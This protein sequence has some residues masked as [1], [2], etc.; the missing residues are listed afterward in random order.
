L[1]LANGAF[2]TH[3]LTV[4][5]DHTLQFPVGGVTI[6]PIPQGTARNAGL[7]SVELPPGIRKGDRYDIVVRQVTEAH[8]TTRPSPPPIGIPEADTPLVVVERPPR[9]FS[10]RQQAG[11]FQI[12]IVIS[13]KEQL[14]LSEERLLS[15][16]LW[17]QQS[18]PLHSR[19]HL[20]FKRYIDLVRGR[21]RGFG[22]DP[23]RIQPSPT[24][25]VPGWPE[26]GKDG[27]DDFGLLGGPHHTGKVTG[28]IYD[29]F[30]DFAGF[31]LLARDGH[32]HRF[33]SQEEEI[34]DL[35]HRAWLERILITVYPDR[36][37]PHSPKSIVLRRRPP[38]RAW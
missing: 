9:T 35:V 20:V 5:G 1:R 37:R 11:A 8:A 12:A 26:Q 19:W 16:L 24:G 25:D 27:G 38:E 23:G 31:V 3:Q 14:L 6:I 15:W 4:T 30:G 36:H 22:G 34:E 32:E 21:V 17:I 13:T 18:I 28:V 7:L 29:R 2:Q 33:R 10:W